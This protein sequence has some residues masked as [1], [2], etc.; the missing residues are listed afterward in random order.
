MTIYDEK[1]INDYLSN[2]LNNDDKLEEFFDY[3]L[4]YRLYKENYFK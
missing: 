4:D 2:F 3:L 1:K